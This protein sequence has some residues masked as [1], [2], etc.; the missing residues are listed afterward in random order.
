MGLHYAEECVIACIDFT[1]ILCGQVIV[2]CFISL[3]NVWNQIIDE[4]IGGSEMFISSE[5]VACLF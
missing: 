1:D 5:L 2:S 4:L 3:P